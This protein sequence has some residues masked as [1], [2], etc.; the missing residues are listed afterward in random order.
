MTK[1]LIQLASAITV[2]TAFIV[3]GMMKLPWPWEL[4]AIWGALA[5]LNALYI[6]RYPRPRIRRR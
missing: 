6:P 4:I 2:A 1:F 5:L 3:I